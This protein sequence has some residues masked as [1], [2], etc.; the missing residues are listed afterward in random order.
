MPE[1]PEYNTNLAA[2]YHVMSILHRQ[3]MP[4]F[5]SVGNKKAID[6]LIEDGPNSFT[7]VDVK[8]LA[9]K[10][11]WPVDNVKFTSDRHFLVL[12]CFNGKIANPDVVPEVY[13]VPATP[14]NRDKLVYD[15]PGG[16]SV[17]PLGRMR[18]PKHKKA[19]GNAWGLLRL[20]A[21]L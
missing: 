19:F 17:I 15:A 16:R 1:K 6:I 5:L 8:G 11:N 9:G 7:M 2:E 4:A 13:V 21:T 20:T 14:E 10:S 18:K 3:G 12:V